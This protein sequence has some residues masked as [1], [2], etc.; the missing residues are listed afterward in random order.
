MG[1]LD[2][3]VALLRRILGVL[4]NPVAEFLWF[5][6]L[7]TVVVVVAILVVRR[8]LPVLGRV[9][10]GLLRLV[11]GVAAAMLLVP[12]LILATV[13]RVVSL[14]PPGAVSGYGDAVMS[15]AISI[16]AG[17]GKAAAMAARIARV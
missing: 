1:L 6:V 7:V 16:T 9:G 14:R 2:K 15:G 17:A 10:A 5:P 13:F 3:L 8:F 4:P 12:D 11:L